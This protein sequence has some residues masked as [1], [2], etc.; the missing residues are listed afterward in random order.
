[1]KCNQI[2]SAID[3]VYRFCGSE[4]ESFW[5]EERSWVGKECYLYF[6]RCH[7]PFE[8]QKEV[9]YAK[10]R[11]VTAEDAIVGEIMQS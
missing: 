1:M 8:V 5:E 2:M 10:F 6:G 9:I 3:S 4:V 7:K 11:E